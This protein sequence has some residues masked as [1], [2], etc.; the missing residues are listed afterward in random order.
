MTGGSTKRSL[1]PND[2]ERPL[3]VVRGGC[4]HSSPANGGDAAAAAALPLIRVL[5]AV[6]ARCRTFTLVR[7]RERENEKKG[8]EEREKGERVA[9]REIYAFIKLES[10]AGTT[11]I[12]YKTLLA[13]WPIFRGPKSISLFSSE[14]SGQK[15]YFIS[16]CD[17]AL[18]I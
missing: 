1:G 5:N 8:G 7:E 3:L 9:E 15:P 2:T 11:S 10:P 4:A 12:D 6:A 13:F 16:L 14:I 17:V 18:L